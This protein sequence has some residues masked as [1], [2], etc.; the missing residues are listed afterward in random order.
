MRQ[1]LL[2]LQK[3]RRNR[4]I[5]EGGHDPHQCRTGEKLNGGRENRKIILNNM[6][7]YMKNNYQSIHKAQKLPKI[8]NLQTGTQ[9]GLQ[10]F[11]N[12][13][14]VHHERLFAIDI[15]FKITANLHC[16]Q[17]IKIKIKT[18]NPL[19]IRSLFWEIVTRREKDGNFSTTQQRQRGEEAVKWR[20][21]KMTQDHIF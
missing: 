15:H 3:N 7:S 21:K 14:L 20:R 13:Y 6:E 2:H 19:Q 11:Q 4:S 9:M 8:Q 18:K 10:V 12:F 1:L 17:M 5:A 16:T